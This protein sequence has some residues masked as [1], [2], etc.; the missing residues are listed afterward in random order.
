MDLRNIPHQ[1]RCWQLLLMSR[2]SCVGLRH[3]KS[4]C[5]GHLV[6]RSVWRLIHQRRTIRLVRNGFLPHCWR[7]IWKNSW[8]RRKRS[9]RIAFALANST[10]SA[11]VQGEPSTPSCSRS[12]FCSF[13]TNHGTGAAPLRLS[14]CA[15]PKEIF[16]SVFR[17]LLQKGQQYRSPWCYDQCRDSLEA[18]KVYI[19]ITSPCTV[20]PLPRA[21]PR[22]TCISAYPWNL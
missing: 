7:N 10:C 18:S 6:C 13:W 21:S 3:S 15:F 8:R 20:A 11:T 14:L 12:K 19:Q 16:I 17:G 4:V 5:Y 2:S 22:I 9:G 1:P